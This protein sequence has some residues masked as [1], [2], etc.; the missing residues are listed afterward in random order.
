MVE[1][2]DETATQVRRTSASPPGGTEPGARGE[3]RL[4]GGHVCNVAFCPIGLALSAVQPL[5]PDVVEHLLLAGREFFLAAKALMDVA[6]RRP[7]KETADRPRSRRSTSGDGE[8]N[9]ARRSGSTSA[10]RRPRRR[11]SIGDGTVLALETLPT[12]ADDMDATLATMVE[13]ARAG[14]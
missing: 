12:P 9:A 10:G 5:K 14:R 7:A 3:V 6:R 2:E 11:A 8:A 1:T 4:R 13:A